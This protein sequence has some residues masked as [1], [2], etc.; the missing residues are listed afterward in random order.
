MPHAPVVVLGPQRLRPTLRDAVSELPGIDLEA[1]HYAAVTAGWEEREGEHKEMAEHLGGRTTNLDLRG[2]AEDVFRFDP[3][4]FDAFLA[5][6]R[7]RGQVQ[8]LYRA[9]L[10]HLL[11][12]ARE[13]LSRRR[14]ED[15]P[16]LLEEAQRL[17]IEDVRQLDRA[18]AE[19]LAE[20]HAEFEDTW[21]PRERE[22]VAG[23][24][25][26]LASILAD[27][28][29]LCIAG[30][31]VVILLNR[32]RLFD[33]LPLAKDLPILCWS[34]GAMALSERVVVF[35]D[36]P[37]QGPGDAEVLDV[38]LGLFRGLVPLPHAKRRLKLDDPMRVELFARRFGPALCAV[39]DEGTRV[40]WDGERW[41]AGPGTQ[42]LREDGRLEEIVA[43]VR[44]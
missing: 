41:T 14:A 26:E 11:D 2:R 39:L 13:L 25:E 27:S 1:A 24:R 38:G 6:H 22:A 35:H 5:Q 36:S 16:D 31:H 8:A 23:H 33:V 32:L 15:D 43:E 37:P 19:R 9:R 18:H 17:A 10:A 12:A 20:L 3:D 7:R 34:A 21:R 30:G 42:R 29:A 44:S 4:F 40:D 28:S